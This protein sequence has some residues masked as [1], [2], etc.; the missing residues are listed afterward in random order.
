M[1][2]WGLACLTI[3]LAVVAAIMASGCLSSG[4]GGNEQRTATLVVDFNGSGGHVNP[5][6]KTIWTK[7]GNVWTSEKQSN[8]G[9]TIWVF[10]N[11][12]F[13]SKVLDLLEACSVIGGFEVVAKNYVGMGTF[14]EAIDQV[15]NEVPGRGW[16]YD[17]NRQYANQACNL[18]AL[19][20]QDVV[21]WMFADMPW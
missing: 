13:E 5:G 2:T 3:T 8:N 9:H 11:V 12:T 16:Q 18:Y 15:H 7:V 21:T 17:V 1:K 4:D 10:R 19:N 14:V 6:D 20:D